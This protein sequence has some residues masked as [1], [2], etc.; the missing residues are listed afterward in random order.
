M[1]DLIHNWSVYVWKHNRRPLN[2]SLSGSPPPVTAHGRRPRNGEEKGHWDT[3]RA[4]L[5]RV[6]PTEILPVTVL[7]CTVS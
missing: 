6:E 5:L 7:K 3:G 4:I 1:P 2:W